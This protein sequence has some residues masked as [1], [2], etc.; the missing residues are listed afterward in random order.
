MPLNSSMWEKI[1]PID[2]INACR[3]FMAL[4]CWEKK[5]KG[6]ANGVGYNKNIVLY[7]PAAGG[8]EVDRLKCLF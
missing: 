2:I 1:E 4:H 8:V 6:K 3:M 5:K 7:L